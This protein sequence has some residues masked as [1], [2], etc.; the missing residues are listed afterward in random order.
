MDSKA[1]GQE[2][3]HKNSRHDPGRGIGARL[4]LI[5]YGFYND[6]RIV[7]MFDGVVLRAWLLSWPYRMW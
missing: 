6:A 5:K 7:L 3:R 1:V 4:E 2:P